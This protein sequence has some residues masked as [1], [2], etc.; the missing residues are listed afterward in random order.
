MTQLIVFHQPRVLRRPAHGEGPWPPAGVQACV[1]SLP[2]VQHALDSFHTLFHCEGAQP[3][4]YV[5]C[6][7]IWVQYLVVCVR[8][9]CQCLSFLCVDSTYVPGCVNLCL[10]SDSSSLHGGRR[11]RQLRLSAW[12]VSPTSCLFLTRLRLSPHSV[13]EPFAIL[14]CNWEERLCMRL[15]IWLKFWNSFQKEEW[16]KLLN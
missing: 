6:A 4:V 5:F 13:G 7:H 1:K 10:R 9:R 16:Y 11:Y 15:H 8:L 2:T 14:I 3:C 12:L